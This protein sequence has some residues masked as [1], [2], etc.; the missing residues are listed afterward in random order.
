MI[1]RPAIQECFIIVGNIDNDH[2]VLYSEN[3][4]QLLFLQSL[5]ALIF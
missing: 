4:K 3:I 5:L 1:T 2:A